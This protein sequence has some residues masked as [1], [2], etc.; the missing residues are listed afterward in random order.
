MQNRILK[1]QLLTYAAG[2]VCYAD[3]A[4]RLQHCHM[5]SIFCCQAK[6]RSQQHSTR[7]AGSSNTGPV[8]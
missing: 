6:Q 4:L 8:W 2:H 5:A 3:A 1:V 7:A